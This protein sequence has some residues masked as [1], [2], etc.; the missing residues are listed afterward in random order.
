[1]EP[2]DFVDLEFLFGAATAQPRLEFRSTERRKSTEG[3]PSAQTA[4]RPNQQGRAVVRSY[5]GA[6]PGPV[7]LAVDGIGPRR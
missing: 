4:A 1:M 3:L 7:E 6:S 2:Y 5:V